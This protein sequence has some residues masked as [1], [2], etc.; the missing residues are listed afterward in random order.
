MNGRAT[1]PAVLRFG[2]QR[3]RTRCDEVDPTQR[4]VRELANMMWTVLR[5][6]TGLAL[7]APQVG[8]NLRVIVV[9]DP[10]T[11]RQ[12]SLVMI[13]PVIEQLAGP[14]EPF[15]EGCL[16]FPGLYIH[17]QRHRD[18]RVAYCDLEGEKQ[19]LAAGGLLAR[20]IQHEIDHLNGVLFIDHLASWRRWFLAGRL[21]MLKMSRGR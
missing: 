3:L 7:A 9:A 18:V 8:H 21:W 20:I 6:G 4:S 12:R 16:S 19:Q 14:V 5:A 2:D 17:I 1:V 15:E 10:R 11:R 13:N